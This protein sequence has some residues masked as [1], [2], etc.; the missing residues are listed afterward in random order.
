MR[1]LLTTL[2]ILLVVLVAG[3]SSLV[4]L[5]NPNDFRDYM[6]RQV[7][8]RSGYQLKLEG[9]LRWHVWPQLSI[10]S[11]PMSLKTPGAELPLVSAANMR[12]DVGLLPLLSHRLEVRQV[13][14]KGAVI[15]LTSQTRARRVQS[16]PIAPGVTASLPD[17]D[18]GWSFD[19][20]RLQIADSLLV[21]ERHRGD[22]ITMRNINL[23][24]SQ[25]KKRRAKVNFSG[26]I[27]RNQRDLD[28]QFEANVDGSDYPANLNAQLT[29]LSYK[30][31]GAN[32]PGQGIIGQGSMTGSWR[33][34]S[35]TLSFSDIKISAND[36]D[37]SGKLSVVL[38]DV[39]EW[40]VSLHAQQLNL[41]KLLVVH[42][43]GAAASQIPVAETRVLPGPVI[44]S[45][46][47]SGDFS[48]LK[49]FNADV[50][51][52]AATIKWRGLPMT[53]FNAHLLNQSGALT[54]DTLKGKL[55]EGEFSLPGTIDALSVPAEISFNPTLNNI[56]LA[57]I[58]NAFNYPQTLSGQL[59]LKGTLT[60][61][62]LDADNFRSQWQGSAQASVK[63]LRLDGMNF[64]MLIQQAIARGNDDIEQ[65]H[66]DDNATVLASFSTSL[67][68][69]RGHLT[70]NHMQGASPLLSVTGNG[71]LDLVGQQCDTQ[72][73][74]RATSGWKGDPAFIA[75]LQN[76]PLP[77]RIFGSWQSLNYHLDVDRELR[78][79]LQEEAKQRLKAWAE[80]NKGTQRA[81]EVNKLLNP[82]E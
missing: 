17:T 24:M 37:L 34:S 36:S 60:G 41:D 70:L 42:N 52:S 11:G 46:P 49:S 73:A 13:L 51:I 12:L 40:N 39:P 30:L 8:L 29:S 2:M 6:V 19:I 33:K 65:R 15:Q 62:E 47:S 45:T 16:P 18:R 69:D 5:V 54:I 72:F 55:A 20:G 53:Q 28:V 27:N 10:L 4:L 61:S 7:E 80:R 14:V 74:I 57:Q 82:Q 58:L 43:P 56:D 67:L 23:Q 50:A 35:K 59:T 9:P 79:N 22:Q 26:S 77:L 3:L 68:L 71:S 66:N 1:R 63:R 32:L 64:L 48:G 81:K 44:A 21:F 75:K 38:N 76:T 31:S 78:K 25:D